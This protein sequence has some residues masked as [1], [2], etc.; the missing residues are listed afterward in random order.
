MWLEISG[1]TDLALADASVFTL[2]AQA[3]R[4]EFRKDGGM[5]VLDFKTGRT[6]SIREVKAGFAPQLVLEAGMLARGA[7]GM[8]ATADIDALYIKLGGPDDL[9]VRPVGGKTASMPD[10]I[11]DQF[12]G[13]VA[14]LNQLRDPDTA[15][16]SRPYPQFL[17]RFGDYDH[18]ARA[19]EWSSATEDGDAEQ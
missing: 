6:P 10:L 14:L 18:L 16:L 5:T 4:I 17:A 7:F 19:K 12:E 8:D 2:T 1:N 15:Y 3:D 11:A 9:A 13:V